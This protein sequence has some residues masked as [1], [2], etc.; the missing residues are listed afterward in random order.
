MKPEIQTNKIVVL[1]GSGISAESGLPTFRDANGLWKSYS[2]EEVASPAGWVAH[3]ELVLEFYNERRALAAR[4][5][6]NEAHIALAKLQSAY[7]VVVITQNVDDLHERAGSTNVIHVH[8][9]LTY[10]RGT[11]DARRRYRIGDAPIT[12]GQLCED[13]TQLRPDIVWFGEEVQYMTEARQHIATAAKVLVVGTSL[14]V[15]PAASL[16]KS[17]RGRAEK[18]LV[19]LDMESLPFGFTFSRGRATNI[20]PHLCERWLSTR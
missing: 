11:S 4:A 18:L 5:E 3:P 12:I 10:A 2:W 7:E 17:A 19:A 8:G 6:P 9:E 14:T 15:F 13:G 16:V 1:S 20:I